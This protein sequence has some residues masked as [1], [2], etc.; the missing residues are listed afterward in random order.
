MSGLAPQCPGSGEIFLDHVGLFVPDLADAERV[1][2]RL[3]F[4]LTPRI[5]HRNRGVD[6]TLTPSGTANRCAMLQRGY[7]E[8]LSAVDSIDNPL[9]A[10]LRDALAR[11][12]GIHLIAFACADTGREA[13]RLADA[14]FAPRPAVDLRRPIETD[15]G[16]VAE[17][18]FSVIRLPPGSFPEG[19]VQ[20]L[21]H[22]TPEIVWQ[23]S[24]I[25]CDNAARALAGL[26]A[27]SD[28]PDAAAARFARLCG[29][30]VTGRTLRLDR[31][32]IDF[33]DPVGLARMLPGARPPTLPYNAA[34][35]IETAD[36]ERTRRFLLARGV[37]VRDLDGGAVAVPPEAALGTWIV[38]H[39]AETP[40]PDA[41]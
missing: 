26:V 41:V 7:I 32:R 13:R 37:A 38:F 14:G 20:M 17:A 18:A 3:G 2:E 30:T 31:G 15:A 6:G 33:V 10:E 1:Y 36:R 23:P 8:F 29:R 39:D 28:D 25:A 40:F 27:C 12:T 24:L 16:G 21:R 19:R 34:L 35:A 9:A 22:K 4:P 11:H 5:L